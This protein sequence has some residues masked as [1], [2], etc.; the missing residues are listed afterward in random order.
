MDSYL[1]HIAS[2]MDDLVFMSFILFSLPVFTC[3]FFDNN[4]DNS[5][6]FMQI[7]VHNAR[8]KSEVTVVRTP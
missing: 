3:V 5:A 6:S 7:F 2:T 1:S 8:S 4:N